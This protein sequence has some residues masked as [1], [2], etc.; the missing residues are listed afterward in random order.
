VNGSNSAQ[1]TLD[2]GCVRD[3]PYGVFASGNRGC[4]FALRLDP[5]AAAV[6]G[7]S[8]SVGTALVYVYPYGGFPLMI[9]GDN[10]SAGV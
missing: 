8:N 6:H 5:S 2:T 10:P 7:V 1:F 9:A 4:P 3:A